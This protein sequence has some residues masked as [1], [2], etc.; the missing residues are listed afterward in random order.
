MAQTPQQRRANAQFAREQEKKMGKPMS[1]LPK[2][3]KPQ[4]APINRWWL[5]MLLFVVCG[6]LIFEL[7]RV[8]ITGA[9][10]FF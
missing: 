8:I 2:K 7:L 3:E 5:Y 6:G 9:S 10:N 1:A 4:K